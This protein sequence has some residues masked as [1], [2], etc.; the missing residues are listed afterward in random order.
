MRKSN[1]L[2]K[3]I[4]N[5][6]PGIIIIFLIQWFLL[7][8]VR[9]SPITF[10][11]TL[12]RSTFH[13]TYDYEPLIIEVGFTL[14]RFFVGFLLAVLTA[15]PLGLIVGRNKIIGNI[16]KLPIEAMRPIPAA[17]TIPLLIV[18]IGI[19]E[20]MKYMVVW[21]GAFWPLLIFTKESSR[22][23]DN[24]LIETGKMF[25]LS[26]CEIIKEIVFPATLPY[27]IAGAKTALS[28]GLL[29]T[30]T[31]EMFAGGQTTGIGYFIYDSERRF[32]FS[33]FFSGVFILGIIGYLLNLA[34]E[35]IER[36]FY[37][38]NYGYLKRTNL[39]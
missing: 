32:D 7:A 18:L 5:N 37:R 24:V 36:E 10:I 3:I 14:R 4:R 17:V 25:Q 6:F 35:R 15:I 21:Y 27:I 29:L 33:S 31:V 1:T 2:W 30:I 22:N 8:I 39:N 9:T 20:E 38:K 28:I 23:I 19:G 34:F 26:K 13:S 16:F 11:E 12:W